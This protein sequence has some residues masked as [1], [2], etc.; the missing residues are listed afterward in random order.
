[1]I[2]VSVIT[3]M[4]VHLGWTAY[5]TSATVLPQLTAATSQMSQPI[6]E[7]PTPRAKD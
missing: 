2:A 5:N 3:V 4:P 7:K 6:Q 1:M